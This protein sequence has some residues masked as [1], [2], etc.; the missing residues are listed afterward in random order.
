MKTAYL[1]KIFEGK[2]V[3]ITG[4]TGFK[5]TWLTCVL[6]ILGAEIKGYSLLPEEKT[7]FNEIGLDEITSVFDDI[8]NKE[9]LQREIL[10]FQPDFIF[11]LAAQPLVIKSYSEPAYTYDV[12]V[13]GTANLL[14]SIIHL[15]NKSDVVIITTDKVYENN[16]EVQYFEENNLLGGY[17]PYSAS[18]ACTE[19][20]VSSFRN[21]FFN[22]ELFTVHGKTL[23]TARSGN[24]IGGGDW[25]ANRI[26]PDIVLSLTNNKPVRIRN[27][28]SVRPWLH[29]L[30]PLAGYLMMAAQQSESNGLYEHTYNFGP[31]EPDHF[32]VQYLVEESIKFWGEGSWEIVE[33]TKHLHEA[34]TLRLSTIKAN[35]KLNWKTRLKGLASIHSTLEWY[36][37]QDKDRKKIME[38]QIREYFEI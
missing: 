11:H 7:L 18:K 24:V 27:P 37:A 29:V 23:S 17:D 3:F 31:E 28:H 6:K 15:N 5:G 19:I 21:S 1:K 20:L 38:N 22:P 30:E 9:K 25:N 36:K 8:R 16:D 2:K 26:I 4:H 33:D 35:K 14:E 32:S 34:K 13:L 10:N 12:N